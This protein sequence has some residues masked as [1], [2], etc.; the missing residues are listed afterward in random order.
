MPDAEIKGMPGTEQVMKQGAQSPTAYVLSLD[1]WRRL[2]AC[3][4]R[5]RW[6][7]LAF[8]PLVVSLWRLIQEWPALKHSFVSSSFAA[9]KLLYLH[10]VATYVNGV[11]RYTLL[12]SGF[13]GVKGSPQGDCNLMSLYTWGLFKNV[14][15]VLLVTKL[16]SASEMWPFRSVVLTTQHCTC[17]MW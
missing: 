4:I 16:H 12:C 7:G 6:R 10:T 9:E 15:F 1:A 3:K 17:V 2:T 14:T 11:L 5:P 8:V 13:R